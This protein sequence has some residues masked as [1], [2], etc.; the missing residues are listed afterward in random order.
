MSQIVHCDRVNLCFA[1]T[2][3]VGTAVVIAPVES[4]Q[5]GNQI[6]KFSPPQTLQ[7][8]YDAYE[9]LVIDFHSILCMCPIADFIVISK[10]I[11]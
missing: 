3:Q 4:L 10:M 6:W 1:N 9:A 11:L 5:M 8:L 2:C 7:K